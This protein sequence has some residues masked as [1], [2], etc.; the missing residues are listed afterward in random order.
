MR[1]AEE[2]WIAHQL[3]PPNEI[4]RTGN[5]KRYKEI[6]NIPMPNP[7]PVISEEEDNRRQDEY[8]VSHGIDINPKKIL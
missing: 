3:E 2:Y 6:K 4:I 7:Y 1:T 5:H 8:L